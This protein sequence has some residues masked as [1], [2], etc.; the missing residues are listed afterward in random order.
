M[1]MK[2]KMM[3]WKLSRKISLKLQW[4]VSILVVTTRWVLE[5]PPFVKSVQSIP[6]SNIR[7]NGEQCFVV[8][9]HTWSCGSFNKELSTIVSKRTQSDEVQKTPQS[10]IVRDDS[11]VFAWILQCRDVLPTDRRPQARDFPLSLTETAQ[12]SKRT[13]P[14]FF[15]QAFTFRTVI[16]SQPIAKL[17]RTREIM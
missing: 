15:Q 9:L 8:D 11:D 10:T 1:M 4:D 7:P 3:V 13:R 2:M 17:L 12:L 16:Q 6:C 5:S 14:S